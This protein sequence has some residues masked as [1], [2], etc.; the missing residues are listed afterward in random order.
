MET[1]KV[2]AHLPKALLE[3]ALKIT[4]KGITETLREG[5][6]HMA[7]ENACK[8]LRAL[9]GKVKFRYSAAELRGDE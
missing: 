6:E 9:R 3:D 1:Q 2:T 5:L 7:R 4:G 8:E